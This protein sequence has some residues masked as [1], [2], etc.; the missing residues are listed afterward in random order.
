MS[1][2]ADVIGS[3]LEFS[4]TYWGALFLREEAPEHPWPASTE[5]W[6]DSGTLSQGAS[7]APT[8]PLAVWQGWSDRGIPELR[9]PLAD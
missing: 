7:L 3:G 5:D 6:R 1:A 8:V 2:K 9:S 4:P